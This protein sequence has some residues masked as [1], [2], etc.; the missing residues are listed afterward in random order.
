M[1]RFSIIFIAILL[2]FDTMTVCG[3]TLWRKSTLFFAISNVSAW[4]IIACYN[5]YYLLN[6]VKE[7]NK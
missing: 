2:A 6:K 5:L 1:H 3:D 4:V 7:E